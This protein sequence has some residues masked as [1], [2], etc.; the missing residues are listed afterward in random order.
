MLPPA[1]TR[2]IATTTTDLLLV[3][4]ASILTFYNFTET[5]GGAGAEIELYDGEAATGARIVSVTLT[6]GESTRDLI[7]KPG[8]GCYV[9]LFLHVVSG[10]IKGAVW[11][12][13]GELVGPYVAVQGLVPFWAGQE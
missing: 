9:G 12:V 2:P 3:G 5:T 13:T 8:L 6:G 7:P 11:T 1:R 10:S 4:G